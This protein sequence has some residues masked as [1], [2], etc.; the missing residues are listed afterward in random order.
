MVATG[1]RNVAKFDFI[2]R[3]SDENIAAAIKQLKLLEAIV[4]NDGILELTDCGRRMVTFPLDPRFSKMI[5]T[6]KTYK[7]T[8]E[9]LTIISLLSVDSIFY[10]S[11]SQREKF[12]EVREKFES[13]EGDLIM[14]LNVYKAYKNVKGN[15]SW[16]HENCINSRN[17]KKAI[18][19]RKQLSSLCEKIGIKSCSCNKETIRIRK[20][21]A[22]G[23]FMNA[24]QLQKDKTYKMIEGNQIVKIHPSSC[25]FKALPSCCLY[26]ELVQTSKF[27]MRNV[28]SIWE[29]TLLEVAPL[30]CKDKPIQ[31][32]QLV[33]VFESS[34]VNFP[35]RPEDYENSKKRKR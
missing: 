27:F 28:T 17:V 35:H 31:R 4:E 25:L 32:F 5:L 21:L 10:A 1:I 29:E 33:P 16:C 20:C 8:D 3:P 22:S 19:V 7:C 12:A 9:I 14:L 6:S 34:S 24:A 30:Y 13:S 2:D 11:L 18:T 23:L 15:P 26:T